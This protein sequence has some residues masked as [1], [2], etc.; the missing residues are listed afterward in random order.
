V[1]G[2][3]WLGDVLARTCVGAAAVITTT[4]TIHG[5]R[6]ISAMPGEPTVAEVFA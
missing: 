4:A 1:P 6:M 2:A 5:G 3:I